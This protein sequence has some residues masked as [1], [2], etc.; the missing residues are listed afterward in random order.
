MQLH[1][2]WFRDQGRGQEAADTVG[3]IQT[4]DG[5]WDV[6]ILF[7]NSYKDSETQ[8][9]NLLNTFQ[10]NAMTYHAYMAQA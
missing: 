4:T 8:W 7:C 5:A 3:A 10:V 9:W 1:L 6:A 2:R